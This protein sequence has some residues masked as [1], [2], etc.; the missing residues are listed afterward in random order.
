MPTPLSDDDLV[1]GLALADAERVGILGFYQKRTEFGHVETAFLHTVPAGERPGLL[2]RARS[3]V[4]EARSLGVTIVA[5][6]DPSYPASLRSLRDAPPHLFTLG[7]LALLER[8]AVAIVGTRAATPYGLRI[9]RLVSSELARAGAVVVSGMA[10]GID[11]AAHEAA[12]DVDGA[13]I[14]VLGTGVDVPYPKFNNALHQR[15]ARDG[16]IVSELPCGTRAFEGSFPRR[17]RL[18]AALA[19]AVI[20][21]EAPVKSGALITSSIA[22]DIGRD[23]GVV[24][25]NIDVP[26]SA[27]SNRLLFDGAT[28]ILGPSDALSLGGLAAPVA[29]PARN[30]GQL[31][32]D[33]QLLWRAL[34]A[35]GPLSA[36]ALARAGGLE[37]RRAGPALAALEIAGWVEVDHAGVVFAR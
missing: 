13:T 33:A 26:A 27:G 24:P 21:T 36:D 28:P 37:A 3:T 31:S 29:P 2:D 19:R 35:S 32:D 25:G 1:F 17:N 11:A 16:L 5:E 22:G 7:N 12:L 9:T 10:R 8:P 30:A 6:H 20:V 34:S 4:R 14:A 23:V 18:I 15:I